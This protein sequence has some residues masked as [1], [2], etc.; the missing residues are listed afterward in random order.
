MGS[1]SNNNIVFAEV[2][3]GIVAELSSYTN[4]DILTWSV[5]VLQFLANTYGCFLFCEGTVPG[6][7]PHSATML[8]ASLV[9]VTD[10]SSLLLWA[11]S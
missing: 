11:Q 8:V 4:Q 6:I 3:A 5:Y 2:F 1:S 9:D 10:E 7:T